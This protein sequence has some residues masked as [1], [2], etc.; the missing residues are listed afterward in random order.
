MKSLSMLRKV[1]KIKSCWSYDGKLF[2]TLLAKPSNK[3]ELSI[4]NAD[5][6]LL[7]ILEIKPRPAP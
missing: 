3:I 4:T 7:P 2:Y 5:E 1:K 6:Q